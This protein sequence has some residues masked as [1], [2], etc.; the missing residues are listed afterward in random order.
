[1]AQKV[2]NPSS[3]HEVGGLI[4]GLAQWAKGSVAAVNCGVGH[5]LY[6]GLACCGCGLGW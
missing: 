5:R 1:M 6:L 4:P 3:I 2:K